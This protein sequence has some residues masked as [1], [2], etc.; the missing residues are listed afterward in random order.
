MHYLRRLADVVKKRRKMMS[1]GTMLDPISEAPAPTETPAVP[2][3]PKQYLLM[4]DELHMALLSKLL[5]GMLFVQ[6]EGMGMQ[7]NSTH[8]L[9]VNP[10]AA[11]PVATQAVD[12]V[13]AE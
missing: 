8:M 9:L 5:P 3:K 11:P 13:K 4:A 12:G 2:P 1:N 10:V 7:N 6:V